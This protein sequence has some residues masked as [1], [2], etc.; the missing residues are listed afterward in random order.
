MSDKDAQDAE[1][2]G[3]RRKT[4]ETNQHRALTHAVHLHEHRIGAVGYV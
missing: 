2:M 4:R 1:E 3:V